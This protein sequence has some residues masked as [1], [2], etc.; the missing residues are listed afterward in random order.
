[1]AVETENIP[2]AAREKLIAVDQS[3]WLREQIDA[4]R[5]RGQRPIQFHPIHVKGEPVSM[6]IIR[7]RRGDFDDDPL[8]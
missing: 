6:T 7:E 2:S 8:S 3:D 4:I 5:A 1:M